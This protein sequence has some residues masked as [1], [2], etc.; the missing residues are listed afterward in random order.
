MVKHVAQLVRLGLTDEEARL[1]SDQFN[2][3]IGYFQLLNAVDTDSIPPANEISSLR[4]VM[5]SDEV[6]PSMPREEFLENVPRREGSYVRVPP[7]FGE[8]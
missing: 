1:F 6:Q 8:E 3:I 4:S 7:V 5:R 2:E